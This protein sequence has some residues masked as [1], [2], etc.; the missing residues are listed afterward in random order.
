MRPSIAFPTEEE[1]LKN[2]DSMCSHPKAMVPSTG[3]CGFSVLIDK[4]ALEER[5]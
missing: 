5:I 3:I 1:V 2:I 4:I